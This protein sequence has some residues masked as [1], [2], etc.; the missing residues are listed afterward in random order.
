MNKYYQ[1]DSIRRTVSS[2]PQN[3]SETN[4]LNVTDSMQ[5]TSNTI[6]QFATPSIQAISYT[7]QGVSP[8]SI[9]MTNENIQEVPLPQASWESS[10]DSCMNISDAA[11]DSSL[12]YTSSN[13]S[14]KKKSQLSLFF[15]YSSS[16]TLIF[17]F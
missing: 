1:F 6:E 5:A 12:C 17:N 10:T 7:T 9:E 3:I 14:S 2:L 13:K 11:N 4:Q 16:V 8:H 15:K